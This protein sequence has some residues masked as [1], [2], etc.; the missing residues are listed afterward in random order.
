MKTINCFRVACLSVMLIALLALAGCDEMESQIGQPA[1]LAAPGGAPASATI[2]EEATETTDN[3]EEAESVVATQ[4]RPADAATTATETLGYVSAVF[5]EDSEGTD[6]GVTRLIESMADH[7]YFFFRTEDTPDGMVGTEDVVLLQ[8]NVQWAERGGTNTDLISSVIAA[9]LEHPD[10]FEGEIIVADN[11]Q[12][13]FGSYRRGGNLDWANPNSAC[14]NLSTLDVI[15]MYQEMGYRVTGSLWDEFTRVQVEEFSEGDYTDGFVVE[16]YIHHTGLEISYPKFTT[17]FGTHVSFREGIWDSEAGEFDSDRLVVIN[18]PVLKSHM[19]FQQTGAVKGYMGTVSDMLT[20]TRAH[21]S[22]G[23]GGMGTQMVYTR[24]P[25]LNIMDMIWVAP[26]RGPAAPFNRAVEINKIAASTDPVALDVWTTVHVLI[27]EAERVPGGRAASM[28]PE[29]TTPG[30]F[31]HW[32]RL[33]LNEML[34]A[35]Y[36][37]TMDEDEIFVVVGG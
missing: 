33:S 8:I 32:L 11:G 16:D 5:V 17:E 21:N 23:T 3:S 29:G 10:G 19:L 27:P 18:M 14:R 7:G 28:T 6:D 37:F 4:S 9:I 20:R 2:A 35:G 13:Q 12:A 31:G 1:D 30:T 24:M 36:E 25:V 22:V 15:L 26:D 34:A